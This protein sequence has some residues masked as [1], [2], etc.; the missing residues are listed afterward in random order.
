[1][2]KKVII[3]I[4]IGLL[5][6]LLILK[7][8]GLINLNGETISGDYGNLP[9]KCRLPQGQ[10]IESWKEHLGHHAETQDCLRYFEN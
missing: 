2:N 3:Y 6:L 4:V 10:D 1:M 5:V 8:F 9:E 7:N